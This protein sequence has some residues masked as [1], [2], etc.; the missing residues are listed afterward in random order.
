MFLSLVPSVIQNLKLKRN[1]DGSVTVFWEKP[2]SVGGSDLRY[3][4]VVNGDKGQFMVKQNYTVLQSTETT[5]Y[6]ISVCL[7]HFVRSKKSTFRNLVLR[8]THAHIYYT[9]TH[10]Y[11]QYGT[12]NGNAELAEHVNEA[13]CTPTL[14]DLFVLVK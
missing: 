6:T 14:W 2:A 4:V 7:S 12:K 13:H 10:V 8:H 1:D 11:M 3:F 9:H 5:K